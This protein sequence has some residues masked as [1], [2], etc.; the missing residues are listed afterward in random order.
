MD[1]LA[2]AALVVMFLGL[3]GTV[4]PGVPGVLL[5]FGAAATYA[6]VNGYKEFG[7]GWL[8]VMGAV[9]AASAAF[10]FIAAPAVA[11]RFGASK[12]GVLGALAGLVAGFFVGGP[13]GALIGPLIGAVAA[14]V[15]F[16]RTVRQALRSGV[17]TAVGFVVAMVVDVTAALAIIALFLL[18]VAR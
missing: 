5:V 1:A 12:W 3:A 16:G 13:F 6:F 2:V 8:L 18:L 7:P 11:R 17:G 15:L 14:E 4:I 9:A 10:D